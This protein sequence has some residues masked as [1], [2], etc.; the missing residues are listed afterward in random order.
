MRAERAITTIT[1]ITGFLHIPPPR[2]ARISALP[3]SL[4]VRNPEGGHHQKVVTTV[5]VVMELMSGM[6]RDHRSQP[7]AVPGAGVRRRVLRVRPDGPV[8][9]SPQA[10][11]G[12]LPGWVVRLHIVCRALHGVSGCGPRRPGP[13]EGVGDRLKRERRKRLTAAELKAASVSRE[14]VV[15]KIRPEK[16]PQRPGPNAPGL[17]GPG[18]THDTQDRGEVGR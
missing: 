16:K 13:A 10:Q 4:Y 6:K 5:I 9:R 11:R 14:I 3:G 15:R 8:P 12:R 7:P 18:E 1:T 17:R 2:V